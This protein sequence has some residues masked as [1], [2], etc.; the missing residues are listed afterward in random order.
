MPSSIPSALRLGLCCL[1]LVRSSPHSSFTDPFQPPPPDSSSDPSPLSDTHL[2]PLLDSLPLARIAAIVHNTHDPKYPVDLLQDAPDA[3]HRHD[4]ARAVRLLQ[5]AVQQQQQEDG[6]DTRRSDL[7]RRQVGGNNTTTTATGVSPIASDEGQ[8]TSAAVETRASS[9]DVPSVSPSTSPSSTPTATPSPSPVEDPSSLPDSQ[10]E[11]SLDPPVSSSPPPAN[12][13]QDVVSVPTSSL[14]QE[15]P[16]EEPTST[17]LQ[18]PASSLTDA[19]GQLLTLHL[20][21][22]ASNTSHTTLLSVIASPT[23]TIAVVPVSRSHS[24]ARVSF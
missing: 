11:T 13:D 19:Q 2:Q 10:G 22:S 12:S 20:L 6:E 15:P 8:S 5:Q 24:I 7:R 14:D 1:A 17:S 21:R 23:S 9:A 18:T 4:P 3:L 16:N